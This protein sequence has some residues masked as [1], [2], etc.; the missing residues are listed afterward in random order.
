MFSFFLKITL[1]E[2]A[3]IK[4]ADF[5]ETCGSDS[6]SE[7]MVVL[8]NV[9]NIKINDKKILSAFIWLKFLSLRQNNSVA[10]SVLIF[11]FTVYITII[12]NVHEKKDF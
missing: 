9:M 3:Q 11:Y 5:A 1:P 2:S 10:T 7:R 6:S 8:Q 12:C 4:I